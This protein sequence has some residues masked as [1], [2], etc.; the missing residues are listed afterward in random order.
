MSKYDPKDF[1]ANP[2]KY[3]LFKTAVIASDIFTHNGEDDLKA[4]THVA[5]QYFCTAK[6]CMYNR[7]EP[8]YMLV[9]MDRTMYAN[10]LKDF[11]L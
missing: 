2:G 3:Q 6:N 5:I 4:G 9:G 11:V 1:E 10:T 8:V 7:I